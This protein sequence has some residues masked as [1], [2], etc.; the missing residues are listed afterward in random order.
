M[1]VEKTTQVTSPTLDQLIKFPLCSQ[2]SIQ[3]PGSSPL[4]SP[5]IPSSPS[6]PETS[7]TINP[8]QDD[9]L[10]EVNNAVS[11]ETLAAL[12]CLS[13]S[14]S[15]PAPTPPSSPVSASADRS[16]TYAP[17]TPLASPPSS[18]IPTPISSPLYLPCKSPNT[19]LLPSISQ[20]CGEEIRHQPVLSLPDWFNEERQRILGASTSC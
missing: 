9:A 13:Q 12:L 1:K 5:Q 16:F 19:Q 6:S 10:K 14:R 18:P 15:S 2:G 4:R 20:I 7:S 17:Q 11:L 8:T 3:S